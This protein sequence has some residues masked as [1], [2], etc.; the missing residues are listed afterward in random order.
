MYKT[1]YLVDEK[2]APYVNC[3]MVASN[4]MPTSHL[5][6]PL[7]ADGY[8]G[9]MYQQTQRGF[10][11]LPRKKKLSELF[12]YGQTLDPI[13]LDVKGPYQFVVFQLYPFASKHLLGV[14][15]KVLNDDCFDL[16]PLQHVDVAS[17][18][19]RLSATPDLNQQMDIIS[20]LMLALI[21]ENKI[22]PDN[23]VQQA[24]S[25]I[26]KKKGNVR[27]S[28]LY[29]TLHIT[30]RTFE[31]KF[32]AEVGLTPKQFC[33]IIQF[34]NCLN[35]LNQATFD[36]LTDIGMDSGFSDQSHFT[37]TFKKYTGQTP[38]YYLQ[39]MSSI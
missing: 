15:P 5:N 27:L 35:Q 6:I 23:H 33:K 12:L 31:R 3:V 26:L 36:R 13:S 19:E 38:S 2:L 22:A 39:Q 16:L 14:D 29:E 18:F 11:I 10:Y 20:D 25:L 21:E 30:E 37:R 1:D 24:I 9:I 32:M 28:D 34:Q 8:P 7:Y 4:S 17:Y